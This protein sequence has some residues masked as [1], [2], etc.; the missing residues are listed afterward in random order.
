MKFL[1]LI[2]AAI[3]LTVVAWQYIVH[4]WRAAYRFGP[5]GSEVVERDGKPHPVT[6]QHTKIG[7]PVMALI[8]VPCSQSLRFHLRRQK[9]VHVRREILTG[10]A[11][12]DRAFFI[13]PDSQDLV[14]RL[15]QRPALRRHFDDLLA[16]LARENATFSR[17]V[18]EDRKLH[19][20]IN[21]RWAP[22]RRRLYR[23]LL[24]WLDEL[25][26]LLAPVVAV[27]DIPEPR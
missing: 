10:D 17:L 12:L 14:Q 18:A 23:R 27:R 5:K 7:W 3:V 1:P 4:G 20:E 11:V 8:E 6:E 2:Q 13:E 24:E 16:A 22:D 25:D 9:R 19:L 26:R 21:V 15:A